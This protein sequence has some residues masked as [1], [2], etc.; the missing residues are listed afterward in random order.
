MKGQYDKGIEEARKCLN[1]DPN[2]AVSWMIIGSGYGL[3]RMYKEAIEA[4]QKASAKDPSWKGVLAETYAQAGQKD[5]ARKILA[6]LEKEPPSSF[7]AVTLAGL[8]T[9]LGDRDNAFKWL[10]YE[11][12]HAWVPWSVAGL[13]SDWRSDPRFKELLRKF[14]LPDDK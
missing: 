8:Y 14:N 6:E 5:E 12:S 13:R 10:A 2:Y 4:L 7:N 3:K 11:P 1:Q 9:A